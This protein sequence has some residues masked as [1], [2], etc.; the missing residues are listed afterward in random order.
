MPEGQKRVEFH[1]HT[2]MSTMDA[3]STVEDLSDTAAS[4]G[5]PAVAIT[6]HANVQSFPHGYHR[7]KKAGIKAIF[8]LEANLVEDKVPIVYNSEDLELKE[9]TYVVFDVETTGLSAVHNDLIQIA[10]NTSPDF[11]REEGEN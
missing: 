5:H 2:N 1:A 8:G 7:A 9:A 10:K 11:G 6:D 4:W 3:M